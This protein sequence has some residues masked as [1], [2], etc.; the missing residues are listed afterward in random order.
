MKKIVLKWRVR[1]RIWLLL[2]IKWL[3]LA[4]IQKDRGFRV[5]LIAKDFILRIPIKIIKVDL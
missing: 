4:K 3:E 2:K 5:S 1:Y